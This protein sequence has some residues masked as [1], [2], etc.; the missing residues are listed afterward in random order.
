M[1]NGAQA[2]GRPDSIRLSAV[3]VN[4]LLFLVLKTE[5]DFDHTVVIKF[6]PFLTISS[7]E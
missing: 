2:G 4:I 1:K 3:G 7:S 6:F 5:C